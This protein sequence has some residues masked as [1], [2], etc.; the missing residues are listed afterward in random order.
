MKKNSELENAS[1]SPKRI[2]EIFIIFKCYV[3]LARSNIYIYIYTLTLQGNCNYTGRQKIC[4]FLCELGGIGVTAGKK[5][6]IVA[7]IIDIWYDAV[8]NYILRL[9]TKC[10]W[11]TWYEDITFYI[12]SHYKQSDLFYR[13]R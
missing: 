10:L 3:I 13:K 2:V 11:A 4:K 1:N 12:L 8:L 9:Y 6:I 5:C 7:Y